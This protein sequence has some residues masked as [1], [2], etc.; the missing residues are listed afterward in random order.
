MQGTGQRPDRQHWSLFETR[1]GWQIP[2]TA[3]DEPGSAAYRAEG[4][5]ASQVRPKPWTL[6]LAQELR[7]DAV[8]SVQL[9]LV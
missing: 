1:P 5:G 9:R 7:L 6:N 8:V 3:C 4:L 2:E